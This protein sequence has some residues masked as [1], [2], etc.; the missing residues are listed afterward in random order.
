MSWAF[1]VQL[2][3]QV[4][5]NRPESAVYSSQRKGYF[6]SNVESGQLLF[7]PVVA[8]GYIL[9][10]QLQVFKENLSGPMGLE[11]IGNTLYVA[12]GA[13]GNDYIYGFDLD[14][15]G[16]V[17]ELCIQD[18]SQLNDLTWDGKKYLYVTDR[19]G[20]QVYRIDY[21]ALT[22]QVLGEV[23]IPTPNGIVYDPVQD[24]L[25]VVNSVEEAGLFAI[26]LKTEKSSL[27]L[28]TEYANFDGI[29][30]DFQ[31]RVY[32]SSWGADWLHTRILRWEAGNPEQLEVVLENEQ[33][34]ADLS[35]N[36]YLNE[37]VLPC[38][39]THELNTYRLFQPDPNNKVKLKI[40]P[41]KGRITFSN[42]VARI[43]SVSLHSS[44]WRGSRI[45]YE[46]KTKEKKISF[47]YPEDAVGGV[48]VIAHSEGILLT[49]PLTPIPK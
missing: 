41:K 30:L 45:L 2:S 27:L 26:D 10:N 38:W 48:I 24:R 49:T 43:L 13:K 35:F 8:G 39:W 25:L 19:K 5:Y 16:K 42:K 32:I 28:A 36:P 33:G 37:L 11:I 31:N 20:N 23:D 6:I 4:K 40:N 46:G 1:F 15:G 17:F 3:A 22:F 21:E 44:A 14:S 7:Q 12:D 9:K 47:D 29:A 18:A 34:V